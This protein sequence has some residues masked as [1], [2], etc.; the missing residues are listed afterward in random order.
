M[1]N[2]L[3]F[4]FCIC[5]STSFYAQEEF[6]TEISIAN[7]DLDLTQTEKYI[8]LTRSPLY[9]SVTPILLGD[10]P[11]LQKKGFITFFLPDRLESV[12]AKGHRIEAYANGEFDY[13]A[14][15][16]RGKDYLHVMKKDNLVFG[17]INIKRDQL[18]VGNEHRRI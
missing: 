9:E 15:I 1:K 7:L 14:N 13:F 2:L 6:I 11:I 18:S 16:A 8:N 5:L 12:T 4:L 10:L 3:L 17:Q